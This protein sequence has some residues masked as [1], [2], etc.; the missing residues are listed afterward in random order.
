MFW[1]TD[2]LAACLADY[3]LLTL[4][5]FGF[6]GSSTDLGSHLSPIDCLKY[7]QCS[8]GGTGGVWWQASGGCLGE[9]APALAAVVFDSDTQNN[10]VLAKVETSM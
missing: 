8:E 9:A 1:S 3:T 10:A 4:D 6:F 7:V 5:A 2:G